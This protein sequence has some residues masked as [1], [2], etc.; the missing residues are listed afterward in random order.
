ME[1]PNRA[2]LQTFHHLSMTSEDGGIL[3]GH[4]S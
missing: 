4:L 2:I 3:G 1:G